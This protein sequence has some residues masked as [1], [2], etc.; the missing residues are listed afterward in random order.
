[1][2]VESLGDVFADVGLAGACSKFDDA[3]D[4]AARIPCRFCEKLFNPRGMN[5]HVNS[6][7]RAS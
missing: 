4:D 1:M 6:G 5:R 3:V 2:K 7:H